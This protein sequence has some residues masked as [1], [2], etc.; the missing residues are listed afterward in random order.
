MSIVCNIII[1]KFQDNSSIQNNLIVPINVYI[2]EPQP[3]DA[4]APYESNVSVSNK[5]NVSDNIFNSEPLN[6]YI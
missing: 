3:L 4:I 2:Q 5:S 1:D 6:E